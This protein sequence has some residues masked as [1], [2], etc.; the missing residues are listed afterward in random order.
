MAF[1]FKKKEDFRTGFHRIAAGQ[2]ACALAE[3]S[4]A[5]R[6]VARPRDAPNASREFGLCVRLVRPALSP[7]DY[8]K[9]N[10]N[11]RGYRP[12]TIDLPRRAGDA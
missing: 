2:I 1:R 11:L 6:A 9:E 4:R 12:Q 10:A 3:W 7:K 8:K 5:D